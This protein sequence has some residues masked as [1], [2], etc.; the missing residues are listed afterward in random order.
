MFRQA[1]VLPPHGQATVQGQM[2]PSTGQLPRYPVND[3][4]EPTTCTLQVPFGRTQRKKDVATG[5][6]LPPKSGAMYD[7][8]PI[9]PDSA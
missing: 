4:M 5:V 6:A 7:G 3:I 1:S 9:P 2:V 8:K